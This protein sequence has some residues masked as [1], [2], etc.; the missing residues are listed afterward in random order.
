MLPPP[1]F[2]PIGPQAPLPDL[3]EDPP[4]F[5]HVCVFSSSSLLCSSVKTGEY[6]PVSVSRV[7]KCKHWVI[8]LSRGSWQR[9]AVL[10]SLWALRES[11]LRPEGGECFQHLNLT[12]LSLSLS[13]FL[14]LF[15]LLLFFLGSC[16]VAFSASPS[17]AGLFG[18]PAARCDLT[19]SFSLSASG[20]HKKKHTD[21]Y[22]NSAQ[23]RTWEVILILLGYIIWKM[24]SLSINC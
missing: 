6:I 2:L 9:S 23:I 21:T 8:K 1:S 10:P 5:L 20:L 17:S 7:K 11:D 3:Q 18:A 16:G 19:G 24:H 4:P 13:F 15:S 14:S 12:F 22:F